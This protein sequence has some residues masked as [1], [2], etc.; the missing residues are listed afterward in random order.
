MKEERLKQ[1]KKIF[2][3]TTKEIIKDVKKGMNINSKDV[4][5]IYAENMS[6]RLTYEVK[7]RID[8]K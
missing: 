3:A 7:I 4:I 8:N 5:N 2:K 1:L 6:K